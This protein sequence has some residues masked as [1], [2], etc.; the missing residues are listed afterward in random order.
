MLITTVVAFVLLI[1][2]LVIAHELGH[3]VTARLFKVKILEF[4]LGY[5]PRL[6]AIK[7]NETEYSVNALPIGGF[8][9]MLGE[10]DP[11]EPGSLAGK[12]MGARFAI[13][14]AG[15]V[16]NGLLPVVLLSA[17]L[18]IPHD[19]IVGQVQVGEVA[20]N[21]PAQQAGMQPGDVI[22]GINDRPI[23]STFDLLYNIQLNI[24]SEVTLI[25]R[26]E[27][28]TREEVKLVPRWNPPPEQGAV[29]ISVGMTSVRRE[30]RSLP[31]WEAFPLGLRK[32][33]DMLTLGKN[34][35]T[36]W[37][38]RGI[39]P[40]VAGPVGIAQATGEVAKIGIP[41]LLEWTAL[42]SMNF[43]IINL[44]P[45]PALDGG[46][47]AFLFLEFV[48]RGKRVPP[49]KEGLVHFIGFA[50]LILLSLLITYQDILRIL[51]GESLFG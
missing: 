32:S 47:L 2:F 22:L 50:L 34:E 21:S 6:F 28:M 8:V 25:V 40:P 37:F 27:R 23:E 43:A 16:M 17:S 15:S 31:I 4:G 5:P 39:A 10:E 12:S 7:R 30:T 44:F 35:V 3:F 38:I 18:M 9:K 51:R 11:N 29:G 36:G 26:R 13:L 19:V 33:L 1:G 46:R 24:G 41:P 45:L 49:E 20:P 42:I 48:R 14:S